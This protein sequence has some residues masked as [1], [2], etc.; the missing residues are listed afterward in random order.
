MTTEL[1]LR[2]KKVAD[3]IGEKTMADIGTDHGYV[4][5]YMAL[6]GKIEKA[7]ACDINKGPLEKAEKNIAANNLQSVIE[8]RLGSGLEPVEEGEVQ[9]IVIAGMGG[10]LMIDILENKREVYQK[11]KELILQPQLDIDEVRKYIHKNGFKI[12]DEDFFIDAGKY[13]TVIKAL[14]GEESYENEADYIFGKINIERKNP[15]LKKYI[16]HKM[17]VNEKIIENIKC[18]GSDNEKIKE[19]ENENRICE[20]VLKRYENK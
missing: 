19:I 3:F 6:N 1:S 17:S 10:M 8:T 14:H 5:I 18:N 12:A 11:A 20:E 4:P 7:I 2:L 13:Y 15:Y 16:E 9:S